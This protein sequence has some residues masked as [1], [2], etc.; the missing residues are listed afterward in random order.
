MKYNYSIILLNALPDKKIKSLGNKYLI[1]IN[2]SSN[3]IDYQIKF[4]Q[5]IFYNP[6]IIIVGGF[7]SKRLKK[8][9]DTNFK[10][11]QYVD[12]D[13]NE[14][15]NVGASIQNGMKYVKHKNVWI[16]NSNILM[17]LPSC[18][19]INKNLSGSF[20]LTYKSKNNIGYISDNNKL[21][22][23]YYDLPNGIIDSVFIHQNDIDKF[24]E[25][26]DSNIQQL[27]FFEV[28]NLCSEANI[29][30][31]T[32]DLPKKYLHSIDSVANIEK[33]KNKLCIN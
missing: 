13:I 24:K 25:I 6:Q 16:L 30:L 28:L 31:S 10:N 29:S 32:V 9:I 4:L 17:N 14:T 3:I 19:I 18:K 27:Y 20:V 11:I 8:Y 22:N 21:I 15:T 7:E 23:C 1:K 2:K 5:S 33:L 12:H 26:C